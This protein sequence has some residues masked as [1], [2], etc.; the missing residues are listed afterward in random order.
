MRIF[1]KLGALGLLAVVAVAAVAIAYVKSTG[2]SARP[3]PGAIETRVARTLRAFAVPDEIRQ[4]RNPVAA[5]TEVLAEA[6]AHY[7]DHCAVCHAADGSGNTEM[8][9]GLFPKT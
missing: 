4:R 3:Q 7:A 2:L 8:G 6:L 5:S 1:A 9:R